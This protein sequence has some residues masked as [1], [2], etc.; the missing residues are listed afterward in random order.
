MSDESV[1]V[2]VVWAAVEAVEP[3]KALVIAVVEG[4]Q[5]YDDRLPDGIDRVGRH[6][7]L[8]NA[9][10]VSALG[11]LGD[12]HERTRLAEEPLVLQAVSDEVEIGF[13]VVGRELF[14]G[15]DEH[16]A[17]VGLEHL[18]GQLLRYQ[19]AQ[20]HFR[21]ADKVERVQVDAVGARPHI[22]AVDVELDPLLLFESVFD[23]DLCDEIRIGA[24]LVRLDPGVLFSI[25]TQPFDVHDDHNLAREE[26]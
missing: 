17:V 5:R 18:A 19:F 26:L 20:R 9:H 14:G 7:C 25:L 15:N 24:V 11:R 3:E 4:P 1:F 8:V 12:H 16:P 6:L 10:V 13:V 2:A 21:V 22:D 23:V